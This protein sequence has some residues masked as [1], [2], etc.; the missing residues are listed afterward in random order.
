V[1]TMAVIGAPYPG[2]ATWAAVAG[3]G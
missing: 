2:T 3:F 1:S